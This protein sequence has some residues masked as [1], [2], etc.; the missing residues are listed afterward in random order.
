MG[1]DS[2]SRSTL[3][4]AVGLAQTARSAVRIFKAAMA[5]G[6]HGADSVLQLLLGKAVLHDHYHNDPLLCVRWAGQNKSGRPLAA[7]PF[8]RREP[9]KGMAKHRYRNSGTRNTRTAGS[10]SAGPPSSS[11]AILYHF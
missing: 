11:L 3:Q 7:A 9:L 5:A 6:L 8:Q 10:S 1:E 2:S 4:T